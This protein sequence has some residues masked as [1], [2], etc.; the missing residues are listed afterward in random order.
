VSAVSACAAVFS[1][2]VAQPCLLER[3]SSVRSV[4]GGK[5]EGAGSGVVVRQVVR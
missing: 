1:E 5:G 2:D 3:R 4:E